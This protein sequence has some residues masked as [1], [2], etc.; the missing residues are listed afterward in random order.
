VLGVCNQE[1]Y[2][3]YVLPGWEGSAADGRVLRDA[4]SR[5]N[6]L[7]LPQGQYYLVDAGYT[8]CEGFLAPYRGQRYHLSEWREGRNPRNAQECFNMRHS[9]ARNVIKRCFGM[10]KQRWGIL[11]SPSFYPARTHNKVI[12]ACCLLHNLIRQQG[13]DLLDN[14]MEAIDPDAQGMENPSVGTMET[15]DEWA[16]F[17]DNLANQMFNDLH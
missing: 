14:E 3:I 16:A 11:R 1:G 17:R 13:E 2:F 15:S 4:I 5:R 10:L 8:N 9:S 12:I 7:K 6:G